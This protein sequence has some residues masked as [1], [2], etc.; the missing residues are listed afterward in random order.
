[1]GSQERTLR[2]VKRA[3]CPSTGSEWFVGRL[4]DRGT[5]M[6]FDL[7]NICAT[8]ADGK[9]VYHRRFNALF[10]GL[11]IPLEQSIACWPTNPKD[12]SSIASVW[13]MLPESSWV[14]RSMLRRTNW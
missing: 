7:W 14:T 8:L 13:Q 6:L 4:M 5:R 9:M 1:M 2:R 12:K 3:N 11:V 10:E